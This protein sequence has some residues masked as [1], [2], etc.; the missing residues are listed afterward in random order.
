MRKP[1]SEET[2]KKISESL[3]I[4]HEIVKADSPA[5]QRITSVKDAFTLSSGRVPDVRNNG[6]FGVDRIE[7]AQSGT[8][9]EEQAPKTE[10]K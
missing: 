10:K 2:R 8:K 9:I 3:K 7:G 6:D 1:V 4:Y 5:V